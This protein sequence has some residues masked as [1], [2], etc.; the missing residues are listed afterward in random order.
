MSANFDDLEKEAR[1]LS[2]RE[3]AKLARA[4][5]DDLDPAVDQ[6][7]EQ[8]WIE[9]AQRRYDAYRQGEVAT[10]SGE[11]AMQRARKRLK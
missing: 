3:K 6:G 11:E 2:A 9:E 1:T 4:L 5:I 8:L 10:A 7:A